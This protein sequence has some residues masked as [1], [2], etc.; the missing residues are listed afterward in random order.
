[1]DAREK[2]AI[3]SV[4]ELMQEQDERQEVEDEQERSRDEL[5]R[6]REQEAMV[7]SPHDFTEEE[8]CADT[9]VAEESVRELEEQHAEDRQLDADDAEDIDSDDAHLSPV[10]RAEKNVRREMKRRGLLDDSDEDDVAASLDP[11]FKS[12]R[13]AMAKDVAAEFADEEDEEGLDEDDQDQDE[14]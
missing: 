2:K 7:R 9:R 11:D 13:K 5:R 1:M 14:E 10:A 8:V 4:R 6:T 12:V 3:A